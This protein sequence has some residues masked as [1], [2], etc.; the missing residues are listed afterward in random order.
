MFGPIQIAYFFAAS[1][2]PVKTPERGEGTVRYQAGHED[3]AFI[4]R[5]CAPDRPTLT[6]VLPGT[7]Q[8][9]GGVPVSTAR[10]VIAQIARLAPSAAHSTPTYDWPVSSQ[11]V[12]TIGRMDAAGRTRGRHCGLVVHDRAIRLWALER[13]LVGFL[14]GAPDTWSSLDVGRASNR[15][16]FFSPP[17]HEGGYISPALIDPASP[18]VRFLVE[19]ELWLQY[20]P[21]SE[22]FQSELGPFRYEL[23]EPWTNSPGAPGTV[24]YKEPWTVIYPLLVSTYRSEEHPADDGEGDPGGTQGGGAELAPIDSEDATQKSD[25]DLSSPQAPS[26]DPPPDSMPAGMPEM[27]DDGDHAGWVELR[28]GSIACHHLPWQDFCASWPQLRSGVGN[29]IFL[30]K[31]PPGGVTDILAAVSGLV[32]QLHVAHLPAALAVPGQ[33][34]FYIYAYHHP[35]AEWDHCFYVGKGKRNR[36]FSHVGEVHRQ[37]ARATQLPAGQLLTLPAKQ[38]LIEQH[39]RGHELST[40]PAIIARNLSQAIVRPPHAGDPTLVRIIATFFGV[41]AEDVAF[42]AEKFLIKFRYGVYQL[43]NLAGGNSTG[44]FTTLVRPSWWPTCPAEQQ[45]W[46]LACDYLVRH[47]VFRPLEQAKLDLPDGIPFQPGLNAAAI[48]AGWTPAAAVAGS[49]GNLRA[50]GASDLMLLFDAPHDRYSLEMRFDRVEPMVSLRLRPARVGGNFT[51]YIRQTAGLPVV[52]PQD[53]Y[54]RP[55][56]G[57][58]RSEK[59]LFP[60]GANGSFAD[61]KVRWRTGISPA[62]PPQL[63]NVRTALSAILQRF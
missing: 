1:A 55:F 15:P 18:E 33:D 10:R 27:P 59:D 53:P 54:F 3:A 29:V 14:G 11:P 51:A 26:G 50:M 31:G 39:L 17:L 52:R 13:N 40:D 22:V 7:I 8:R 46:P 41:W 62:S 57:V 44:R 4:E 48:A 12:I 24:Q 37:L 61:K 34:D 23:G 32:K 25:A 30:V 20:H 38:Q 16:A 36:A 42:A 60:V 58:P 63:L 2:L 9:L 43:G 49:I 45:R 19:L 47:G 28:G 5:Y 56:E 35:R 6:S 21:H